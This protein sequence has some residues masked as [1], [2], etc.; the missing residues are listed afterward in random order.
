[1]WAEHVVGARPRALMGQLLS[2]VHVAIVKKFACGT[3]EEGFFQPS[4]SGRGA[5]LSKI[6][7][8][9]TPCIWTIFTMPAKRRYFER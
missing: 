2:Q 8:A 7:L 5:L 1:M 6:H 3:R 9:H 4:A